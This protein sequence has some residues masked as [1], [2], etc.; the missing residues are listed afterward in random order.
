MASNSF[1]QHVDY[2]IEIFNGL[3]YDVNGEIVE[4]ASRT[5]PIDEDFFKNF[6]EVKFEI[7]NRIGYDIC[8]IYDE[9][10]DYV[11]YE[12]TN[13]DLNKV[14]FIDVKLDNMF[15]ATVAYYS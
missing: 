10:N 14:E 13:Y 1:E 9:G 7:S 6:D 3:R 11:S 8:I 5:V 12:V 2:M 4:S 15:S